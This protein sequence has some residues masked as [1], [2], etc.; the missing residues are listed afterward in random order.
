MNTIGVVSHFRNESFLLPYWLEHH[1]RIFD[2]GILINHRST[3]DS[4]EIVKR[5]APGWKLVDSKLDCFDAQRTDDEVVE[6]EKT[7]NT[8]YRMSIN[9]TEFIWKPNYI[10]YLDEMFSSNPGIQAIGNKQI[11]LVDP[12]P[13]L[14]IENPLWKNRHFGFVDHDAQQRRWR[15]THNQSTGGYGLGRH[16]TNLAAHYDHDT[17]LLYFHLAPWPLCLERMLS[18]QTQIPY[19][20]VIRQQGFQHITTKERLEER[21]SSLPKNNLLEFSAFKEG[22]EAFS[23][24]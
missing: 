23:P 15:F 18:I 13:D 12:S 8:T 1:T 20:D 7:L 5:L 19:S 4:C 14:P 9:T 16:T 24:R 3:D 22:Y 2:T 10:E 11:V 17:F 21:W 6:W